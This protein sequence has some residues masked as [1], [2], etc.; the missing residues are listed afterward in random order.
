MRPSTIDVCLRLSVHTHAVVP[1]DLFD[2]DRKPFIKG[3]NCGSP[4]R[5][6]VTKRAIGGVESVGRFMTPMIFP[7]IVKSDHFD[8]MR[9][10]ITRN[11]G[12][13]T[14]AE[15][16]HMICSEGAN[17]Y[18]QFE[19]MVTYLWYN[20]HDEYSWHIADPANMDA[21]SL[22]IGDKRYYEDDR[23]VATNVP[24]IV[25]MKH[26]KIRTSIDSDTYD[27]LCLGSNNLAGNCQSRVPSPL[28]GSAQ[29]VQWSVGNQTWMHTYEEH[30]TKLSRAGKAFRW[31]RETAQDWIHP[32]AD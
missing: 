25:V 9:R 15:A 3:V 22:N 14:F 13:A 24:V 12:A 16:F 10:D 11:L 30:S 5:S 20:K 19:I 29:T 26:S 17:S 28:D 18:S 21:K 32:G 7:V 4:W 8:D 6:E 2:D 27:Y 1:S 23:V 31:R